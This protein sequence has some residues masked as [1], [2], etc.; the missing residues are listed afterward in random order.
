V[1]DS[2]TILEALQSALSLITDE[3]ELREIVAGT[4]PGSVGKLHRA[5]KCRRRSYL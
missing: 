3:E 2:L 4:R 5:F 1:E